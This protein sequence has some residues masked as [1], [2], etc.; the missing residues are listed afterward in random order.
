MTCLRLLALAAW[1]GCVGAALQPA[2]DTF[3]NPL[4]PSGPDPWIVRDGR[5][6]YYMSTLGDRLAIRKTRDLTRLAEARDTI[7]WRPPVVGPNAQSIWAP[8]LHR[9]K[10]KWYLYYTAAAAGHD[11]DDHRGIFVLENASADPRR[12]RWIDRG[13]LATGHPGID[14]TTFAYRGRRYFVYS[15]YVGPDSDLAIVAMANP[16]TLVG[17]EKI[18]ARP[19]LDWERRGGRQIL[20]GP[21]FLP[22]PDGRLFLT[23]SASACWSDDYAIGLLSAPA[24]SDPLD[25]SVWSKSTGPVLAKN[26]ANGV[27]APGHNGFFTSP[28][29]RENWIV[30]HANPGPGMKCTAQRSPRIQRFVFGRD[31]RPIFS[32]PVGSG[33]T[34]SAPSR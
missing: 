31:G 6:Y 15:P 12:G 29:G 11:D 26:P 10:G 1:V 21:E 13:K 33:T 24:G 27:F 28:D 25:P 3:R 5:D 9:I 17:P 16:W 22:G 23:Y 4:L 32:E 20:E 8:E 7:V 18:I 34:L 2:D 30:Y 14:G 19:T